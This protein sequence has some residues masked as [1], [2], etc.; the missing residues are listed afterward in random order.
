MAW[1]NLTK[2][3]SGVNMLTRK[4][5][6]IAKSSS[7]DYIEKNIIKG[8]Y[9]SYEEHEHLKKLVLKLQKEISALKKIKD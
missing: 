9:V 8:K 3:I 4:S 6:Q 5:A 1:K 7:A 2:M